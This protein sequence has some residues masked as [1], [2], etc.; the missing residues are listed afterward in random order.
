MIN[1]ATPTATTATIHHIN[2]HNSS[3]C[4]P[5]AMLLL[6]ALLSLLLPIRHSYSVNRLLRLR[7]VPPP[8]CIHFAASAPNCGPH[9]EAT[10]PRLAL[11]AATQVMEPKMQT[12][13]TG[14]LLL[15]LMV[16]RQCSRQEA[17]LQLLLLL[18]SPPHCFHCS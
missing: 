2:S 12:T 1:T 16:V 14:Q 3:S 11:L 10:R 5:M 7:I 13:T 17:L 8:L 4:M 15:L 18:P 9:A 6:S